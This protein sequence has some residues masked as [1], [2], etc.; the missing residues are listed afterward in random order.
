MPISR[1]NVRI[2]AVVAMIAVGRVREVEENAVDR[3]RRRVGEDRVAMSGIRAGRVRRVAVVALENRAGRE[4]SATNAT[5]VR[6][7]RSRSHSSRRLRW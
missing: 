1:A 2:P 6:R 4:D 7:D 3:V 5:S